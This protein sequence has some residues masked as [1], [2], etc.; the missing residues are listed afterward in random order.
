MFRLISCGYR[1]IHPD[2]LEI[3]RPEGAGNY[4]FV[5]FRSGG[6]V[7]LDGIRH[8]APKYS[9]VLFRP[10]TPQHYRSREL[11]FVNDWFHCEGEGMA[12]FLEALAFPFDTVVRARDPV[13]IT[14]SIQELSGALRQGGALRRQIV[15]CDLR[16]LFLKLLDS[17]R[18]QENDKYRRYY[19]AFAA[20]RSELYSAPRQH[21]SVA[22]LSAALNLSESYFQHIYKELFGVP[23]MADVISA[24]LEHAKYLLRSGSFS[25]AEVAE[26]CGY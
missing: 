8:P 3:Q 22:A 5:F 26:R 25:V 17:D 14:R 7:V 4:A 9:Y 21:R 18:S 11:P 2:G 6:E 13:M 24:R 23:V 12:A 16:S 20:L 10:G 1:F 15:D 19:A